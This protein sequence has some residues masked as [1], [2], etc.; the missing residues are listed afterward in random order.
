LISFDEYLIG[1]GFGVIFVYEEVESYPWF[2]GVV[3][4][5]MGVRFFVV[6]G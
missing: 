6:G 5:E 1:W 3:C 4:W 2:C